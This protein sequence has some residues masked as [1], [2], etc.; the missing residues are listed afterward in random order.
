MKKFWF[1]VR[2]FTSSSC[3]KNAYSSFVRTRFHEVKS[4]KPELSNLEVFKHLAKLY[5]SLPAKD[6]EELK[7]E[8]KD[9]ESE[10]IKATRFAYRY[11]MP[12]SPP[13]SGLKIFIQEKLKNCKGI[14]LSQMRNDFKD[15]VKQWSSLPESK[16]LEYNKTAKDLKEDYEVKLKEWAM[17]NNLRYTKRASLLAHRF[18]KLNYPSIKKL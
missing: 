15:T 12:K 7:S 9:E 1:L 3:E 11:G 16:Q 2:H 8:A 13:N 14:P 10:I 5:K 6:L 4:T 17:K 18:Y